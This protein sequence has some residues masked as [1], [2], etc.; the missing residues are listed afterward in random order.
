MLQVD[1]S[2]YKA[3]A[4]AAL[5]DDDPLTAEASEPDIAARLAPLPLDVLYEIGIGPAVRL[6]AAATELSD[7]ELDAI[8]GACWRAVSAPAGNS[9]TA[10]G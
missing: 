5:P 3:A 8:A 7:G 6:A 2:P 4:H 1:Y 9:I 10:Q